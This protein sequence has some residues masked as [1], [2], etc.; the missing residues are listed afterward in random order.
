MRVR[1]TRYPDNG[2]W[3]DQEII[4]TQVFDVIADEVKRTIKRG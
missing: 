3:L 1:I 2:S 4:V